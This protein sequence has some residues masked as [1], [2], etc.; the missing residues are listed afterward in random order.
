MSRMDILDHPD[1]QSLLDDADL[2]ATAVR[3]ASRRP[4]EVVR[5]ACH[6]QRFRHPDPAIDAE[7]ECL[8]RRRELLVTAKWTAGTAGRPPSCSCDGTT[9]RDD[10]PG[11]SGGLEFHVPTSPDQ[12]ATTV[13]KLSLG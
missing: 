3:P 1:A 4:A 11:K 7:Q 9:R 8:Q 5:M 2:S 6:H 13:S 12:R 10:D